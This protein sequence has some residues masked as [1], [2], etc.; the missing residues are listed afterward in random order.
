MLYIGVLTILP[1]GNLTCLVLFVLTNPLCSASV[2]LANNMLGGVGAYFAMIASFCVC[3]DSLAAFNLDADFS[4]SSSCVIASL[5]FPCSLLGSLF[6]SS[7]SSTFTLSD[8]VPQSYSILAISEL[9]LSDNPSSNI[10]C[11]LASYLPSMLSGLNSTVYIG[12]PFDKPLDS[13]LF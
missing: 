12:I 5:T 7:D 8:S 9:R 11:L 6:T 1:S 2:L 3:K 10:L 4:A 13:I